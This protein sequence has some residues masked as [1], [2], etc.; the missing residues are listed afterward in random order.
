LRKPNTTPVVADRGTVVS[1]DTGV[2]DWQAF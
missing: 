2:A 1:T